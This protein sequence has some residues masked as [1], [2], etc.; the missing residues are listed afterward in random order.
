M[1]FF[2][3]GGGYHLIYN[4][5]GNFSHLRLSLVQFQGLND[6]VTKNSKKKK[7]KKNQEFPL[8]DA[9]PFSSFQLM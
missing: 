1:I 3:G 9:E 2:F 8:S 4:P 7:K 5:Q 6:K